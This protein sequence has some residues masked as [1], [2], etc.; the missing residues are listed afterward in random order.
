MAEQP[1]LLGR[2]E[3]R[4]R[5]ELARPA[6]VVHERRG[7][8][9]VGAQ[10]RVEL[11]QLVADRRH[12]DRVLE[13][14]AGV[15]VVAVGRRRIRAQRRLREHASTTSA[16]SDVVV[17]LR[18]EELEESLELVGVAA[19][20]RRERGRIGVRGLERAHLELE[21]VAELLD[22]SEDVHGVALA[23]ARVEQLDV[24]PHAAGDAAGRVARARAR[25]TAAPLARA[26]LLLLQHRVDA[27]DDPVLREV[28]ERRSHELIL[29]YGP[30]VADVRPFRAERYAE[31]AGRLEDLVAPPYDVIGP[32]ERRRVPLAQPVQRRP[33][34][35]AGLGG[36]GRARARGVARAS[37]SS[38][39]TTSPRTGRSR[40]RTSAPTASRARGTAS[41][42]RS[43]SSRTTGGVVLP[44]E[45][46]HADVEGER[47]RLLRATRTQLEP[48]F[49]LHDGD[50]VELP[51]REPDLALDGERLWRLDSL[52]E[53]SEQLLIADGHHR[54]ETALAFH[55]EDGTRGEPRG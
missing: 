31:R 41:S 52:P 33:P 20:R 3:R 39:A 32:E 29:R 8:Q 23:E 6:D 13:Q 4:R 10:A 30:A 42:S 1:A 35:A 18:R 37:R 49:L 34:D 55:D 40:S 50:P 28:G 45:R 25:G 46:T 2:A 47:L 24:V 26:Q 19:Q 16:R 12:A 38:R 43:G 9:Q 11:R 15:R 14:P 44:H 51:E 22:A 21:P 48:I 36:G 5:A 54:Y 27:V 7:E 17:D 53:I